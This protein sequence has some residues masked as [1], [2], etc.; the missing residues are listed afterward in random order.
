MPN[1]WA[2]ISMIDRL[3]NGDITKH[4]DVY[5]ENFIYCLNVLGFMK[6]RDD[7]MNEMNKRTQKI[8]R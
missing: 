1:K 5:E 3:S 7:Y 4:K 8:K 2:Y 6:D